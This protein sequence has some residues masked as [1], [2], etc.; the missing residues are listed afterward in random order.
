MPN[1]IRFLYIGDVMG[2]TGLDL[3]ESELPKLKK[4][5]ELDLVIAQA[6]NVTSGR[7]CS[8][9][10]FLRLKAAGVD[11]CTAGNWTLWRKDIFSLLEDP[12]QPI[13][14]PANYRE[15]AAG[16]KYKYLKSPFGKVLFISL[17]GQT[18][19]RSSKLKLDNPLTAIDQ[20]LDAE[21]NIVKSAAI[22]NFHGDYSSEKIV[23][24]QYLDGRVSAVI[25]DHWHVPTADA[26]VLP[27]GT[28]HI[29]D[30]GMVGT[31][32]SSLGVKTDIIV[33]RWR[34]GLSVSN[35]LDSDKPWQFN[36]LIFEVD[37]KTGKALSATSLNRIYE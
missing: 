7:G 37:P 26:R 28:A 22:V 19:G 12:E 17:L 35:Q 33:K 25:G 32:N 5:L 31:L 2:S 13:I 11:F 14:R 1:K 24:G 21:R 8:P 15:G 6:E 29:T 20:I 30:V 4:E 9:Q 36:G 16:L 34:D 3:I 18:V 27:K 23:I 10:D